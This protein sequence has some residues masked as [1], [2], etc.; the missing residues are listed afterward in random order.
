MK[1]LFYGCLAASERKAVDAL[2]DRCT[3]TYKFDTSKGLVYYMEDDDAE[4]LF[5]LYD[6]GGCLVSAS[7]AAI[8]SYTY[9]F[10]ITQKDGVI[11]VYDAD[12]E[13]VCE[14]PETEWSLGEII[15][16]LESHDSWPI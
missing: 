4:I 8:H 11:Y 9:N 6:F 10:I 7:P 15:D 2:F 14:L 12:N 3:K 5:G 16:Y 1:A 13:H